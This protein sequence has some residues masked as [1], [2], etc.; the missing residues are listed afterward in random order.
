MLKTM[1]LSSEIKPKHLL[2]KIQ[3][4]RPPWTLFSILG[5]FFMIRSICIWT[6]HVL[7]L[8]CHLLKC[9]AG[10]V[11]K[12]WHKVITRSNT[13]TPIKYKFHCKQDS[14]ERLDLGIKAL[15]I[16]YADALLR[17]MCLLMF[18]K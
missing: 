3:L 2:L 17:Q 16:G 8:E 9:D 13:H 1:E 10:I 11:A 15:M 12:R 5:D 7:I 18:Q 4:I 14:P 6:H